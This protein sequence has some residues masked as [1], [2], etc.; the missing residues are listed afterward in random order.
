MN[1][2]VFLSMLILFSCL[3]IR[4][5][6]GEDLQPDFGIIATFSIVAVDP[7][8]GE[9]GAAVASKYPA[10]GKV[11]PH[12]RAGVGAFC[13]QHWGNPK[14]GK[15]ALDLLAEGRSSEEVLALLLK[16]DP[17]SDKRQ[18]AIIDMD[19][20]AA[21][22]NP[23]KADP[24]GVYWG[25][26]S[27]RFY[28]CQ[29]N[30]LTGRGVVEAMAKAYEETTGSLTDRL[31]AA[32]VAADRAGGDHR[33]RLAAGIRVAKTGH[34]GHWFELYADK[35]NDAVT[36]LLKK[37]V[38][39]THPAKGA[40]AGGQ[41]P[42]KM[43]F[44]K[45]PIR[46]PW[47]TSNI[48]GSPEPPKP[49]V[50]ERVF[51]NLKIRNGLEMTAQAGRL[52]V[53]EQPGKVWSFTEADKDPQA[54]LFVDLKKIEP[55]VRSAY[56]MAFHPDWQ[57]NQQVF[58]S[59]TIGNKLDDGTRLSRFRCTMD[60]GIPRIVPDSEELILTWLSG[61]HNG[62]NLQFGPDGMLYVSTGD[63]TAPNPPDGLKTGQDNSDLLAS[64][65]RIDIN[66][67]DPGK[68]YAIPADNPYLDRENVRPEI[69][70]FGFRNPWKMSF[71]SRGRLW[72]GDV[73][74]ELW[75]MIHL[76]EKGGN[77]GWSAMEAINPIHPGSASPLAPI[78]P[79]V[80]AHRHT[81][82]ASM[83]GG[84]EYRGTRLPSLRGAYVYADYETGKIWALRHDGKTVTQ[85]EE[86]ADTPHRI[87][88]FG[89]GEDEELYYIHYG[90]ES[91]IYRL[92]P[93]PRAG[94][95]SDFPRK[96]SDSG[97]FADTSKQTPNSG[98]YPFAIHEPMWQDGANSIRYAALPEKTSIHTDIK[99]Q[100]NGSRRIT[101]TW[102]DDSVL[103]KTIRIGSK[104]VETQV[105]HF[106][107]DAW[108]G[109]SYRWNKE[110]TDAELVD[111]DGE[112]FEIN[113]KGWRGGNRYRISSRAECMRCHNMWN[114][115]TPAFEP[116][117]LS[118]F[119]GH[120]NQSPRD[121]AVA[122][123]LANPDFFHQNQHGHLQ[124]SRRSG[125]LEKRSRSWLH[126]NCA[127]CHRRHGGGAA[128]LEVNFERSVAESFTLW[129]P[130]TRGEFGL[131]APSIIVPG[132]P[133]RSVLNYR[134]SAVGSGHMPP[135][136]P[137]EID[138]H[139]AQM[140][141]QW[142]AEMPTEKR[143]GSDGKN[144][145]WLDDTSAAMQMAHAIANDEISDTEQVTNRKAGL[146]S[147]N[148][149]ARALFERF[150]APSQRPLPVTLEPERILALRGDAKQGAQLLRPTG[151]LAT[152]FACH[153]HDNAGRNLGPDLAGIGTRLTP[154]QILESLLQPS[155]TIAPEYR[156]WNV[157]TK[158]GDYHSG[159]ITKRTKD[160]MEMRLATGQTQRI[161]T[162]DIE[163][164]QPQSM[165]LMPEGM[166][167]LITEQEAADLIAYLT[168]LKSARR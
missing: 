108:N 18:L 88:T 58:L 36:D 104:P 7:E 33:G 157:E 75:E 17:R 26:M 46:Q 114:K 89:V 66:R 131:D 96:L 138:G 43:P 109:Y 156:V 69:W 126:A 42:F 142:V 8:T 106:N 128:P 55:R 1:P 25:A 76:V 129:Q 56:G 68:A 5:L 32:L 6:A 11:V 63:A 80:A 97:L 143:I 84:F 82:A 13:T 91:E 161:A 24:S 155:K 98:V 49:F 134:I 144:S 61:G 62:A 101:T 133:E 164:N 60:N 159:F 41:K 34:N 40:W 29:G 137:R 99:H 22:R 123:E 85:H 44:P 117:Q 115:F 4:P 73:G 15:K 113:A 160:Y 59:Y 2:H 122:L 57:R 162:K 19:G 118:G 149:Y 121:V 136:G 120:T 102:P 28:A 48:K 165:S 168:S 93:N 21:N 54:D 130:P 150:R 92:I 147:P 77:Y 78:S 47:T 9:C 90:W 145:S 112:E 52:F 3:S 167:N 111:A 45:Q 64:V 71:D 95:K 79:P 135:I 110:A 53:M 107:G 105:L 30:T 119:A 65:L 67:K 35:S 158:D 81:E 141:W 72:V 16:D 39:T 139:A 116:M 70:A 83:T 100:A 37:Y 124:S 10:V 74:W 152:C 127:H 12:V 87:V 140:L 154:P 166:L 94:E 86:I 163:S 103:A 14:L 125:S 153:Q 148:H 50:A 23:A 31:M 132:H 151:K 38:A 27:G 51:A 20:R 146:E